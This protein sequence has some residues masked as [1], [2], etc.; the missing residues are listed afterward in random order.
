MRKQFA[1]GAILTLG[2][3][4]TAMAAE[5]LSYNVIEAGYASSDLD[6]GGGFKL[7]GDG[8]T[9]AGS[10]EFSQNLF[11]FANYGDTDLDGVGLSLFSL[12]AGFHWPLSPALDLTSGVSYERVKVEGAGSDGG[13]GLAVGLRGRAGDAL[14]FNG[15]VKYADFGGGDGDDLVFSAGFRYYFTPAFAAGI[16]FSKWDD[17][18]LS[19]IG[20]SF[21]YDFGSRQ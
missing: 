9:L 2:A 1:L 14:E 6:L 7:D 4:G 5:G 12:G 10:A 18:D 21:R 20:V 15:G 16:D 3:M 11:G 13:Y 8:F 19:T 17:L